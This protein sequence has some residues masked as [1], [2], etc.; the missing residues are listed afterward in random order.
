[1]FQTLRHSALEPHK[2]QSR[3]SDQMRVC[4]NM[5][6][7]VAQ[8]PSEWFVRLAVCSYTQSMQHMNNQ[9]RGDVDQTNTSSLVPAFIPGLQFP[10][11]PFPRP[12][13]TDLW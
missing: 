2:A 3:L 5:R 10:T 12:S 9:R 13:A 11:T 1:M 7:V 4:V 8:G 6:V